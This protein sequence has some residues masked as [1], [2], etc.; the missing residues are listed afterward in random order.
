MFPEFEIKRTC[1]CNSHGDEDHVE[2]VIYELIV[3]SG[4]HYNYQY[5]YPYEAT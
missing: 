3:I 1:A 2:D 4:V 5:T